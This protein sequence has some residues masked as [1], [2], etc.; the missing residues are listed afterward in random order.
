MKTFRQDHGDYFYRTL[1]VVA[2]GAPILL[3]VASS[4]LPDG[5]RGNFMVHGLEAVLAVLVGSLVLRAAYAMGFN[6]AFVIVAS[7]PNRSVTA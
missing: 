4:Q 2:I 3:T 7:E 1:A 6:K 5:T